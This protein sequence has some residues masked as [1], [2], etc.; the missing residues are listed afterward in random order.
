M[1]G[2]VDEPDGD[3]VAIGNCGRGGSGGNLEED[4]GAEYAG[5][6]G[7][8]SFIFLMRSMTLRASALVAACRSAKRAASNVSA[9][10]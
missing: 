7:G 3:R 6:L 1:L 9:S 2:T 10:T 8:S 4:V 5:D